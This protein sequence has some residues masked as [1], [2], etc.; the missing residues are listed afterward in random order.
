M[1]KL[2]FSNRTNSIKQ[3]RSI[4]INEFVYQA[5]RA[6]KDPI[7]LSRKAYF[8]IPNFSLNNELVLGGYHYSDSQGIPRLRRKIRDYLADKHSA[9]ELNANENIIISVGSKIL[10]YRL[11]LLALNDGGEVLLH[12]PAWLSYEDQALLC[13]ASVR[14]LP[15]PYTLEEICSSISQTKCIEINNPNNLAAWIYDFEQLKSLTTLGH[16]AKVRCAGQCRCPRVTRVACINACKAGPG[17]KL[18]QLCKKRLAKTH[19]KSPIKSI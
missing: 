19:E 12:E 8:D 4:H 14:Y 17:H 18:H 6:G 13:D 9:H 2:S 16:D 15:Y 11:M 10:T 1:N 5:K 3:A 7:V